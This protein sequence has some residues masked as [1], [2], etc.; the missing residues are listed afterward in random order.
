ML[1]SGEIKK[2]IL[3]DPVSMP[4]SPYFCEGGAASDQH[5]VSVRTWH[6]F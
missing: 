3:L 5:P 4:A 2:E 1:D 6:H